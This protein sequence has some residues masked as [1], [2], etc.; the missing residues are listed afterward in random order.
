M[1]NFLIILF[2]L[3]CLTSCY[4]DDFVAYTPVPSRVVVVER[5]VYRYQHVYRYQPV[6]RHPTTPH[7][8]HGRR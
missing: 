4:C 6:H 3:V 2:S 7:N 8:Y 5:P 1:K